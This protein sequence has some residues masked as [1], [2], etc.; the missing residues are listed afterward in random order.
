LTGLRRLAFAYPHNANNQ[1]LTKSHIS[2]PVK[3]RPVAV[4][5]SA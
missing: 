3:Q 2:G 4:A 5:R 1:Y